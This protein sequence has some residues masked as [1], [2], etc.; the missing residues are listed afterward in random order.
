MAPPLLSEKTVIKVK[1]E[2]VMGTE[3]DGDTDILVYYE[4]G[5]LI[6]STAEFVERR[7]TGLYLGPKTR[8]VVTGSGGASTFETELITNGAQGMDAGLA[9]L[10][11]A[12]GL[13]QTLEVYQVHST[14][15]DQK[16]IS[17]DVYEDGVIKTLYGAMGNVEF[18]YEAGGRVMCK[19]EFSG[20]F[21]A[22]AD[23]ALPAYAPPTYLPMMADA[24]TFTLGG[25]A[26]KI[27]SFSL[28][29]QNNVQP[30]KDAAGPGGVAHYFIASYNPQLGAD[31]E[32]DTVAGY[33]FNGIRLAG[34]EQAC[35]AVVT[36]GTDKATFTLPK[37]QFM[38]VSPGDREG[39]RTYDINGQCNHD[40][41]NDSVALEIAAAA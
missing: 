25:A 36:D 37:V 31:P 39:I 35:S 18:T 7:G 22:P 8:G 21:K 33:D 16:T 3:D 12:C 32:A 29:M 38:E 11:Q 28:N 27:N 14:F 17:I 20:I 40:S 26:R 13:K 34:T 30:R 1:L 15:A 10:L 9:I 5:Q 19:F 4:P 41:G 6:R 24:A 2:A 23:I